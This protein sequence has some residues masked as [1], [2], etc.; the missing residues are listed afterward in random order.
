M[1]VIADSG[2]LIA[3]LDRNDAHHDW[4]AELSSTEP[5][6]WLVC[7]PVLTE[8]AFMVGTPA[9]LLE[10]LEAR[11]LEIGLR[12]DEECQAVQSIAARYRARGMDL[13]DACVVRL[14]E[15]HR[16]CVVL[17]TDRSD[18]T[19]YRRLGRQS[20]PCRFPPLP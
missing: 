14:S 4:A 7:E 9:P 20:I 17:T 2:F 1:K 3:L 13:A 18:F 11:D 16:E 5:T 10:M 12:V 19:V 6:P 15:R 8:A